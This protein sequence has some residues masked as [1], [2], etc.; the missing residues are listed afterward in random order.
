MGDPE[1][2]DWFPRLRVSENKT[3]FLRPEMRGPRLGMRK[4]KSSKN[5]T[6]IGYGIVEDTEKGETGHQAFT[7]AEQ[8]K[9]SK[10][11]HRADQRKSKEK[12]KMGE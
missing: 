6:Q 10:G 2:T 8:V 7:G 3:R 1:N 4:G 9:F 11:N 12:F 5:M